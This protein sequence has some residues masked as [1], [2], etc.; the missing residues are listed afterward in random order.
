MSTSL[1]IAHRLL[2]SLVRDYFRNGEGDYPNVYA[3]AVL[4]MAFVEDCLDID[5][6]AHLVDAYLHSLEGSGCC[7]S[8]VLPRN[9]T[10]LKQLDD[11]ES[12]WSEAKGNVGQRDVLISIGNA[13]DLRLETPI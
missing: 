5:D 9:E 7:F 6:H 8:I 3:L 10:I 13:P 1:E 11:L 12:L 2:V 4:A